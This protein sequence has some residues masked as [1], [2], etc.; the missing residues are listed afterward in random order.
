MHFLKRLKIIL[1]Y[2]F[3]YLFLFFIS[4]ITY[5]VSSNLEHVSCY[6]FFKDEKFIITNII[7]KDYGIRLDLKGKEK[8]IGYLYY[9]D[10]KIDEFVSAFE[11]GDEVL[12]SGDISDI[13]NNT[14]PDT[15]NYKKYLYSNKIYN[16]IEITDISKINDNENI[17]YLIKNKLFDR[18][19][20]LDKSFPYIS[21]LVFGNNNYLDEDV[22]VSY[23]E[24]GIS[25]LFAISG[26]HISVFIMIISVFLDKI[27]VNNIIKSFILILFLL[28]YM[29]LTNFSMSVLRAGIFTILLIINKIFKLEIPSVNLLLLAFVII[30]FNNPLNLNNVGFQ[31]SFLVT[32][33][34]IIFSDLFNGK[35]KIY[36]LFIVSFMAFLV[37]YP[38]TVN[39]FN[40]VNFLSVIYNMFFVPYVSFLLLP[41]TLLCYIF[42][43]LDSFLYFFIQKLESVSHFLNS[44]SIFKV[45]MCKMN[46]LMIV[47]YFAIICQLFFKW[48]KCKI[49]YLFLLV[50]FLILHY[51]MPF[52]NND[53]VMFFDVGQGDS[54]LVSVNKK[55][56]LID[57]GGLVMYSDKE[58]TYKL[59]KNRI[60]PYLKANGIRKIDNLVLTH[61]DADH[62]KEA[63]YLVDNFKVEKVVFNG[64]EYNELE[65]ELISLLKEKDI[66][67][68]KAPDVLKMGEYKLQFLNTSIYDNENDNSNVIYLE[69]NKYK[70]LFMG[71][72]GVEKEKDIL[73]KY[74]LKDIDVL[75]V[76][77]HG[78][79]TSS[80]KEFIK[81]VNPKYSIISAGKNNRYGHPNKE[82][83]DNLKNSKIYRTDQDGSIMFKIKNNKLKINTCSP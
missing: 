45:S 53:Y 29:F 18:G 57:T 26:L 80:S 77:H 15:F 61:G 40:Q 4:L 16:V 81:E 27:R 74:N 67:Y 76:G 2:K 49:K 60:L 3:I 19:E 39:N 32:L 6:S 30:V 23:R 70:F 59:S 7:I 58:Y 69:F 52:K 66:A 46:V 8:V 13:S 20:R 25:H 10:D 75:K 14:V 47:S 9:D 24:N 73:E 37:S 48:S 38:I 34:L 64:G 78:S 56:T 31:Y 83:L 43:C 41:F 22:L 65:L 17:F 35:G 33:F 63:Y 55:I 11:L 51:F 50:L 21:S 28:F 54:A 79:K 82:A 71:D 62:M 1:Q 42:P 72:A 12:V 68:E 5:F 44:I 36:S